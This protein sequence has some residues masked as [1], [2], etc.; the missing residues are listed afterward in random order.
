MRQPDSFMSSYFHFQ[1][2][3]YNT[4]SVIIKEIRE[5]RD[6]KHIDATIIVWDT[7]WWHLE[8]AD[9]PFQKNPFQVT[10]ISLLYLMGNPK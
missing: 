3:A 6:D 9:V 2:A 7:L 8:H 4:A 1:K 5:W 10:I